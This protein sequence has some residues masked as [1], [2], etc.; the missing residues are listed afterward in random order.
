M[1]RVENQKAVSVTFPAS[2]MPS[3]IVY[4]GTLSVL[5]FAKHPSPFHLQTVVFSQVS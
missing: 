2:T 1:L 4:V 3:S 5:S